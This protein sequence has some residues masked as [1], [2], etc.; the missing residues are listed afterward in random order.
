MSES[1]VLQVLQPAQLTCSYIVEQV[2]ELIL[3]WRQAVRYALAAQYKDR[4]LLILP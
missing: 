3:T 2:E 4:S 1:N